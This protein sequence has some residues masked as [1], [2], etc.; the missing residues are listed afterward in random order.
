MQVRWLQSW[1]K[2][3]T[4]HINRVS[5]HVR[6]SL[7]LAVGGQGAPRRELAAAKSEAS[8][9]EVLE[10]EEMEARQRARSRAQA[11]EG[12]IFKLGSVK[13]LLCVGV[14]LP[15]NQIVATGDEETLRGGT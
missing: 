10:A 9:R 3:G 2:A 4:G 5:D 6:S 15:E 7:V 1:K 14:S 8:L 12:F 13:V 11:P